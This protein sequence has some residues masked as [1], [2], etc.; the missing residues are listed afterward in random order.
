ME[1][2]D[3][4][5]RVDR[6]VAAMRRVHGPG[7]LRREAKGLHYYFPSPEGLIRDGEVELYKLHATL[8][9]DRYLGVGYWASRRGTYDQD[10][11]AK[12][13]KYDKAYRVSELTTM[14][15]LSERGISA[16]FKDDMPV[17][18]P[19]EEREATCVRNAKGNL[20]PDEPEAYRPD[21]SL[22][23]IDTLAAPKIA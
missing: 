6:L 18:R 21:K 1:K 22:A 3:T 17:L 14:V 13:H 7:N 9:I 19:E 23:A 2:S 12:C 8:N 11:S 16:K 4:D 20:V 15:P 5:P 10:M